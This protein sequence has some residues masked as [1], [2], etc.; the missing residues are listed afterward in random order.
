MD[1]ILKIVNPHNYLILLQTLSLSRIFKNK[2]EFMNNVFELIYTYKVATLQNRKRKRS[3]N[4]I[5]IEETNVCGHYFG[6]S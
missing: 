5:I 2:K 3:F 1:M 6:N 4:T